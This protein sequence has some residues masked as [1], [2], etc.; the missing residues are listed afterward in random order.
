LHRRTAFS[1]SE[2]GA[3]GRAKIEL[4]APID[5]I[6]G[7]QLKSERVQFLRPCARSGPACTAQRRPSRAC[8]NL[9]QTETSR[10]LLDAMTTCQ[11]STTGGARQIRA[12]ARSRGVF[13]S[14]CRT[15]R[16]ASQCN[17]SA[18]ARRIHVPVCGEAYIHPL[19]GRVVRPE[20]Y[21]MRGRAG[22]SRLHGAPPPSKGEAARL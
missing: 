9:G 11:I 2:S 6:N 14:M 10:R 21:C 16:V 8:V 19:Q 4:S 20:R 13:V 22:S 3:C 7:P 12:P 18:A 17:P 1:G 5:P 15:R